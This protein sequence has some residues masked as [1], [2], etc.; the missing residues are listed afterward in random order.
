MELL[1]MRW[2]KELC[3]IGE[4][5]TTAPEPEMRRPTTLQD[6]VS[7]SKPKGDPFGRLREFL[8][9]FHA[10]RHDRNAM[11][12]AEPELTGHEMLDAYLAATAEHLA[13]PSRK[14]QM[15]HPSSW[16]RTSS[17]PLPKGVGRER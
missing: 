8:D 3:M 5:Q 10:E 16:W 12:A 9:E 14:E 6:V 1:Q 13:R 15:V 11:L 4:R 17:A 7:R 2:Q